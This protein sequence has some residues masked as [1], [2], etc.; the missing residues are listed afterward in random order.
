MAS[1]LSRI[2]KFVSQ[3]RYDYPNH[4][5]EIEDFLKRFRLPDGRLQ[6]D[7]EI[8]LGLTRLKNDWTKARP[9]KSKAK[10]D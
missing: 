10:G 8:V 4:Q 5:A 9:K 6:N 3:C 1:P 2:Q 7:D